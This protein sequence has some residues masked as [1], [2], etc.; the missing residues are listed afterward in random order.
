MIDL[1]ARKRKRIQ[2]LR[3]KIKLKQRIFGTS[4]KPR[5]VV[6]RSN[7]HIYGQ[8]IDDVKGHTLASFSS[9][10][11]KKEGNMKKTDVARE[12][13]KKLAEIAL[14]K[15]IKQVVFDRNRYKYHG[16]VKAFVE[17]AR[18]GGLKI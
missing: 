17:G 3:N 1:I 15:N 16:R 13:G 10:K 11:I 5:L 2:R 18:E 12:V 6:F 4:E 7:K 9:L 14:A 8:I